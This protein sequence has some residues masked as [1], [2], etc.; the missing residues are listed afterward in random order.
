MSLVMQSKGMSIY[1]HG[2]AIKGNEYIFWCISAASHLG[3]IHYLHTTSTFRCISAV[4]LFL[5]ISAFRHA[6]R[7]SSQCI[8]VFRHAKPTF[9]CISTTGTFQ[10]ITMYSG[11][12][13]RTPSCIL[14]GMTTCWSNQTVFCRELVTIIPETT[15]VCW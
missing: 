13:I 1:A 11:V 4:G 8:S 14:L 3:V 7:I 12:F 6:T 15:Q 2:D 10:C 9:L 5:C